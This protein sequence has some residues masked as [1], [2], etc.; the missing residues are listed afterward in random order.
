MIL[1]RQEAATSD[2]LCSK[3]VKNLKI[4]EWLHLVQWTTGQQQ[5]T[6]GVNQEYVTT[7]LY[8]LCKDLQWLERNT[9]ASHLCYKKI[10]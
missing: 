4:P 3:I 9:A 8:T 7:T 5:T 10:P 2:N 6:A 1:V